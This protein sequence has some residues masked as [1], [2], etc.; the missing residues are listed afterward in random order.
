MKNKTFEELKKSFSLEQV[1]VL[2]KYFKKI[3]VDIEKSK[4]K[5]NKKVV[6]KFLDTLKEIDLAK[7]KDLHIERL[8]LEMEIQEAKG[9]LQKDIVTL[10]GDL[11]LKIQAVK[12]DLVK[13]YI[14]G[15]IAL[16]G[17]LFAILTHFLK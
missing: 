2:E 7:E 10:R 5:E 11:E 15:M 1:E 6:D 16:G 3:V 17:F 14:G 12:N 4:E 13:W 8:K 9:E